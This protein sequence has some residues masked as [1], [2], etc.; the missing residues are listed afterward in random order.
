M[1]H[2]GAYIPPTSSPQADICGQPRPFVGNFAEENNRFQPN[3]LASVADPTSQD[4]N[5]LNNSFLGQSW[6]WNQPD[7]D[8][9]REQ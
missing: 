3:S 8:F 5:T 6:L 2:P 9:L 7:F 1:A 4:I